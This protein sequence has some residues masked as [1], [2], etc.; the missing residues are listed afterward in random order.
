MRVLAV[1]TFTLTLAFAPTMP[2]SAAPPRRQAPEV[3][4]RSA[5]GTD[6][7][8]FEIVLGALAI[9]VAAGLVAT[10]VVAISEGVTRREQC[11]YEE[12]TNACALV[13]YQLDFASGGLSLGLTVPIS[14][15][16]ALLLRKGHRIRQDHR[17]FHRA[18]AALS[19]GGLVVRF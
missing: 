3:G 4:V 19:P 18:R 11:P 8:T 12:A 16:A 9:G 13:P 5:G 10:G 2:A 7:G 6:R 1:R 14:V 15:A 17:A